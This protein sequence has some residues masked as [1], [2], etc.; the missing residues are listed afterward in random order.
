MISFKWLNP[1]DNISDC[2][3]IRKQVFVDEQ[4]IDYKPDEVDAACEHLLVTDGELPVGTA[5]LHSNYGVC[6]IGRVCVAETHRG[7]GI[8]RKIMAELE[9]R[10][11]KL[12]ATVIEL[13]AQIQAEGFYLKLGYQTQ[14]EPFFKQYYLH[15]SMR[16]KLR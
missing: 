5:R 1:D 8:G 11:C 14:G 7:A 2:Y 16:K 4:G 6:H 9:K 3:I 10:A 12:N 13:D 15:V